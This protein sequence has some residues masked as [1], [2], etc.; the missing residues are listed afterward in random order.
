MSFLK[1]LAAGVLESAAD[2]SERQR[3]VA[4][5]ILD[6]REESLSSEQKNKAMEYANS[7]APE[8]M[9]GLAEKL[10]K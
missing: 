7:T 10:K 3:K 6:E 1:K 2:Q 8:Q 5:K 4:N 9:R